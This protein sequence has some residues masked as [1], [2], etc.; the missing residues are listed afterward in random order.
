[1]F[2]TILAGLILLLEIMLWG[3]VLADGVVVILKSQPRSETDW[4]YAKICFA[5]AA[6]LAIMIFVTGVVLW[7]FLR[8]TG[9]IGPA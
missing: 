8:N 3:E 7:T 1:M 4:A 2:G 9:L 6:Y 5:C